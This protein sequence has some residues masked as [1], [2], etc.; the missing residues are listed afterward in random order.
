MVT[1]SGTLAGSD[2][3][4][5]AVTG[6]LTPAPVTP[7]TP[8]AGGVTTRRRMLW[9]QGWQGPAISAW[10]VDV[11]PSLTTVCLDM[12]QSA[13]AGTGKLADPPGVTKSQILA[14][15]GDGV[16]VLAGIEIGRAHV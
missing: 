4:T 5:L 11:A 16:D 7:V 14:L 15:A 2:G 13:G 3:S 1:Y 9:H 12:C 6:T 10:P 8:P